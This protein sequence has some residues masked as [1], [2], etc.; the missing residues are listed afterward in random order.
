MH[1]PQELYARP[2]ENFDTLRVLRT[3][4]EQTGYEKAQYQRGHLT[5]EWPVNSGFGMRLLA[6]NNVEPIVESLQADF[7][8]LFVPGSIDREYGDGIPD[9]DGEARVERGS[10]PF[11]RDGDDLGFGY[12]FHQQRPEVRRSVGTGV[13]E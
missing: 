7:E 10:A 11:S 9:R 6:V 5:V 12:S 13:V 8:K 1:R 2:A 3:N 4:E